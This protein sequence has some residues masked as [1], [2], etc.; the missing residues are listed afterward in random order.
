MEF[1]YGHLVINPCEETE[2]SF[3]HYPGIR[4]QRNKELQIIHLLEENSFTQTDGGFFL[5]DEEAEYHFLYHVLGNMEKWVQIYASTAVKMRVQKGYIGPRIR[6]EVKERTDWLEFKFDLKDIPEKEIQRLMAS[7]EEKR[8]FYRI[9]GGNL[10]SL[11]TPEYQAL[12]SFII[13]MG[14]TSGYD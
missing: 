1:H 8:K 13:D 6:V 3:S 4:R 11:E 12:S 9:P 10:V 2:E 5:Y 14:I 7:I